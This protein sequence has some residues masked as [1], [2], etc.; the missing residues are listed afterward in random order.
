MTK[1]F[2]FLIGFGLCTIGFVYIISYLNLLSI[3]YSFIEYLNFIFHRLEC[4][5]AII[6]LTIITILI[7][8]GGFNEFFI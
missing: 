8:K 3:G 1:L 7:I 4:W 2:I 5:N 6:G